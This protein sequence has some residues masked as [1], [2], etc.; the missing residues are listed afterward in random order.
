MIAYHLIPDNESQAKQLKAMILRYSRLT[1]FLTFKAVQ[2]DNDLS[3]LRNQE[4]LTEDEEQWLSAAA[5]GTRPLVVVSW[6]SKF[7]ASLPQFGYK[8]HDQLNTLIINNVAS[9][10]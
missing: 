8:C 5:I 7:F 2:A 4:L 6:I 1:M 10:R 3:N 9:L